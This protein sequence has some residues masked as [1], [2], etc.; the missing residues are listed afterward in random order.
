MKIIL[1]LIGLLILT[2]YG[3]AA[4]LLILPTLINS[5]GWIGFFSVPILIIGFLL[6]IG[7]MWFKLVK[8]L[9][10]HFGDKE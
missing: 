7:F 8:N 4:L 1:K 5:W 10:K 6:V 3:A 9:I 2:G